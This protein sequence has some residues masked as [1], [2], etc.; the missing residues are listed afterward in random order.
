MWT[1]GR[2]R[3]AKGLNPANLSGVPSDDKDS[4]VIGAWIGWHEE[5][6]NLLR[7]VG[8]RGAD[9]FF[10]IPKSDFG[11]SAPILG[12]QDLRFRV[13]AIADEIPGEENGLQILH[14]HVGTF[15]LESVL[16]K[17]KTEA[18]FLCGEI[19]NVPFQ[20]AAIE[21]CDYSPVPLVLGI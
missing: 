17:K 2:A 7:I 19:V 21:E 10:A 12:S 3:D 14:L 20:A 18:V 5:E 1:E 13:L 6:A 4:K 11:F 9:E 15:A 8:V 16:F